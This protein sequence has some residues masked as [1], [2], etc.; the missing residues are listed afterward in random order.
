MVDVHFYCTKFWGFTPFLSSEIYSFQGTTLKIKTGL[1]DTAAMVEP[2]LSVLFFVAVLQF[3]WPVLCRF[4]W[5]IYAALCFDL[6][7]IPDL[8]LPKGSEVVCS[9]PLYHELMAFALFRQQL[10][11]F[12]LGLLVLPVFWAYKLNFIIFSCRPWKKKKK[13]RIFVFFV[14]IVQWGVGTL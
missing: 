3:C 11:N 8:P 6:H 1:M 12:S 13:K 14:E 2:Y 7:G 4:A 5:L 9:M 10:Q